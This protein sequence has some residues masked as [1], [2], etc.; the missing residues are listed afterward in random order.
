MWIL[1]INMTDRS[2]RLEG[3]PATYKNLGAAG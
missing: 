2:Y 1:R 3:V